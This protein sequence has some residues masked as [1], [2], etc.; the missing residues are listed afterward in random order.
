MIWFLKE[1]YHN[2][3]DKPKV[4]GMTASPV[5]KKG[6]ILFFMNY[7]VEDVSFEKQQ[8]LTWWKIIKH[9]IWNGSME[10]GYIS[11]GLSGL[12]VDK[13]FLSLYKWQ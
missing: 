6:K 5:I 7:S 1:F 11:I 8:S 4:F 2:S 9:V 10:Y 13:L 3:E 12:S